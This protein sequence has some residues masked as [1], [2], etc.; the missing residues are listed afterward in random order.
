M[1]EYLRLAELEKISLADME[2]IQRLRA[3]IAELERL[4]DAMVD[5]YISDFGEPP[6]HEKQDALERS[7]TAWCAYRGGGSD[8][9]RARAGRFRRACTPDCDSR[10]E[11]MV[12]VAD[13]IRAAEAEAFQRGMEHSARLCGEDE[14]RRGSQA[15]ARGYARGLRVAAATASDN[16]R[17]TAPAWMCSGCCNLLA[18]DIARAIEALAN[19]ADL[20][21]KGEMP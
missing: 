8:P 16:D 11:A 2:T 4:G 14:L 7:V 17:C 6:V 5:E 15:E 12:A 19:A 10:M 21:E 13:A 1:S 20:I 18:R 9:G 3:R